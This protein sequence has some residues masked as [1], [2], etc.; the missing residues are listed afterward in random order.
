MFA[1]DDPELS[2]LETVL[3]LVLLLLITLVLQLIRDVLQM[4]HWSGYSSKFVYSLSLPCSFA[5]AILSYVNLFLGGV[6]LRIANRSSCSITLHA[7][8]I[9]AQGREIYFYNTPIT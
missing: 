1:R 9:S 6:T 4:F 3:S 2:S 8:I 7:G 5:V